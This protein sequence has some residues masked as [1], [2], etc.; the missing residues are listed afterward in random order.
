MKSDQPLTQFLSYLRIHG[1]ERLIEQ[2]HTRPGSQGPGNRD[3][4]ALPSGKLMGISMFQCVQAH[5]LEQFSHALL[6]LHRFPFLDFE[7]ERDILEHG[8]ML[9]ECIVLKDESDVPVLNGEIVDPFPVDIDISAGRRFQP[10]DQTQHGR[11]SAAARS[12]EAE[13]FPFFDLEGYACHSL[14]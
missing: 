1:A 10:R 2:Q 12:E 5:Q 14:D 7:A 9:E 6:D 8:Q 3:P 13:E 4:L 11:F